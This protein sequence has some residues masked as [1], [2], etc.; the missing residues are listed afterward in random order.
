MAKPSLAESGSC[1]FPSTKHRLMVHVLCR[2]GTSGK[3]VETFTDEVEPQ[4]YTLYHYIRVSAGD[5][6]GFTQG[7]LL[8]RMVCEQ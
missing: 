3:Q 6:E 5:D 2:S 7:L 8:T 1:V 4:P